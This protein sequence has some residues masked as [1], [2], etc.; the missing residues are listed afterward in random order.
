LVAVIDAHHHFWDPCTV[1]IPW[2]GPESGPLLRSFWPADLT[3]ERAAAGV[4]RTVLVQSANSAED[5]DFMLSLAA[6]DSSIAAVVAWVDLLDP[7]R[8]AER[9]DVLGG[10]GV[11]RGIR[12]LIHDEED[13]HWILRPAVLESLA[14]V[15][16]RELVLELPAVFPRHLDDVPVLA[17]RF[18]RLRIVVD[19]LG[20]PPLDGDLAPW[21]AALAAAAGY[22][23]VCAKLSGLNTA[24]RRSDWTAETFRPAFEAALALLGPE[25]LI[26]GSDWPVL[27]LNGDYGRVWRATVELVAAL[28]PTARDAILRG[29]A[30][31]LY[32]IE[33]LAWR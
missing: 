9:L 17:A 18:P 25:R 7:R 6:I 19:H 23:N 4:R 26:A 14:L 29:N 22:P 15:E 11:V 31:D 2:L 10:S 13:P 32:R 16:E 12:H 27:L 30:I 1:E 20:K 28:E 24:T 21:R 3:P 8:A 33:E 5:T